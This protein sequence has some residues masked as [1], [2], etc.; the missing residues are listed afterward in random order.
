[1]RRSLFFLLLILV[2][3]CKD[4]S[5]ARYVRASRGEVVSS[6]ILNGR[7]EATHRAVITAPYEG[8]VESLKV[9]I[10][11]K[12]E[13]NT[14]LVILSTK[15]IEE[16][17]RAERTRQTQLE[18][19]LKNLLHQQSQISKDLEKF[20]RLLKSRSI[21]AVEVERKQLDLTTN[22]NDTNSSR[23]E[24]DLSRANIVAFQGLI[25]D[26]TLRSPIQGIITSTWVPLDNF[27]PGS[28]VKLGD[29]LITVS[30]G[31]SLNMKTSVKE[32]DVMKIAPG[33]N[34]SVQIPTIPRK[35]WAGKVVIVD[36]AATIDGQTGVATFRVTVR[37]DI[38]DVPIKS[39]MESIA[40][41]ML[42]KRQNVI[43]V[44]RASVLIRGGQYSVQKR[45][46]RKITDQPIVPGLVGDTHVEVA[47]GLVEEDEV[48]AVYDQFRN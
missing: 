48:A 47:Q 27:V 23:A 4:S 29:P 43:M 12:I 39:G 17:L 28:P 20:N 15:T 38:N 22:R 46:G 33:M 34:V 25:N 18:G 21:A 44:P 26:S 32:Q 8:T 30:G 3:A 37:F 41:L 5:S 19:K 7:V 6:I 13:K 1:M 36:D 42:A 35:T 24:L 40:T 45:D 14:P 11:S 10:G 2:V 16:K 9:G 31:G